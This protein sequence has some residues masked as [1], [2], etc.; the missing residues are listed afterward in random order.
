M[1]LLDQLSLEKMYFY[2]GKPH[3]ES[4]TAFKRPVEVVCLPSVAVLTNKTKEYQINTT[5]VAG[6]LWLTPE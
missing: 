4:L 3:T 6:P 1:F 2:I 5:V